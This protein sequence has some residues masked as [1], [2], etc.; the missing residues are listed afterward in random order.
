M[1]K[2]NLKVAEK[3]NVVEDKELQEVIKENGLNNIGSLDRLS[4][5]K[6]TLRSAQEH[7]GDLEAYEINGIETAVNEVYAML[8]AA[9]AFEMQRPNSVEAV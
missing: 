9:M 8:T 2:T 5:A 1:A 4:L 6:T 7:E 3:K